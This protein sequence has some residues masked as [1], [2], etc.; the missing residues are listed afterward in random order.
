MAMR[1]RTAHK[2]MDFFFWSVAE[3][4]AADNDNKLMAGGYFNLSDSRCAFV[5]AT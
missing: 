3:S 2:A 5:P 4:A 1:C